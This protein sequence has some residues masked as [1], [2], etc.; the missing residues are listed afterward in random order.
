MQSGQN[1]FCIDL[2]L[3]SVNNTFRDED[4]LY[5]QIYKKEICLDFNYVEFFIKV[6]EE[7]TSKI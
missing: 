7:N 4:K 5:G 6:I 3:D 1:S 2:V